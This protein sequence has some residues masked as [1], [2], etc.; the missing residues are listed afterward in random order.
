MMSSAD[1]KTAVSSESPLY[2]NTPRSDTL[3]A[4]IE[5][6]DFDRSM[7]TLS[8]IYP[9]LNPRR[10]DSVL[11]SD[12][13]Y[14]NGTRKGQFLDQFGQSGREQV[15]EGSRDGSISQALT[16]MNGREIEKLLNKNDKG[17]QFA[18]TLAKFEKNPPEAIRYVYWS[19]LTREPSEK[20]MNKM[21]GYLEDYQAVGGIQDIA[22][23]LINSREFIFN[24]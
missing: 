22:W 18:N 17:N 19:I 2:T 9:K 6:M 16:L 20:E 14:I 12:L 23:S 10:F 7:S 11:S 8:T 15:Y 4:K 21:L 3:S 24:H 5:A 13:F 1:A